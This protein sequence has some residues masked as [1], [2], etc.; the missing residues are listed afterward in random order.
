MFFSSLQERFQFGL[1]REKKPTIKIVA[2]MVEKLRGVLNL[3]RVYL[4]GFR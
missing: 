3:A 2:S 4:L 1:S